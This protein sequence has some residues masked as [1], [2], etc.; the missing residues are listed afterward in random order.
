MALP[1]YMKLS[2]LL[3]KKSYLRIALLVPALGLLAFTGCA[4]IDGTAQGQW[5]TDN[6]VGTYM[7]QSQQMVQ[8][9]DSDLGP[10]YDWFY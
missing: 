1:R 3:N 4:S 2:V 10:G 7:E 5:P 6:R 8:P 9:V